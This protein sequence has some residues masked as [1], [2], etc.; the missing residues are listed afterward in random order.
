MA[1]ASSRL[2]FIS[3]FASES[4]CATRDKG[5]DLSS[6]RFNSVVVCNL[7]AGVA[8]LSTPSYKSASSSLFRIPRISG[9]IVGLSDTLTWQLSFPL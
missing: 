9:G 7:S 4:L 8:A 6:S 5:L 1:H 2:C 3:L